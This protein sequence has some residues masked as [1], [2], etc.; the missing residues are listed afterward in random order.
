MKSSTVPIVVKEFN[1]ECVACINFGNVVLYGLSKFK[2]KRLNKSKFLLK[3][4]I[5]LIT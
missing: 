3:L 1:L 5:Y 4:G 2:P